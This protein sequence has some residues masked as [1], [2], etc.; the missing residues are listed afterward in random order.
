MIRNS[1][2]RFVAAVRHGVAPSPPPA[3]S[4]AVAIAGLIA[5]IAVAV[6]VVS[7]VT[8]R[9]DDSLELAVHADA[10]PT[11]TA[12]MSDATILGY[13]PT[14]TAV[15][16]FADLLLWRWRRRAQAVVLTV[17]MLGE[18]AWDE[19][20]KQAFHRARPDLFA[21]QSVHSFSFPSGHAFA[22]A[23]LLAALVALAWRRLPTLAGW[24]LAV[25]AA[26]LA[27]LIG[28]SRV[29]LGVH[30][31]SDILAGW[32]AA[33]AWLGAVGAW[34]RRRLPW[35]GS[36]PTDDEQSAIVTRSGGAGRRAPPAHDAALPRS[37]A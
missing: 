33:A 28:T 14:L 37:E 23:C 8:L 36:S 19:A 17:T 13:I 20:L 34:L 12:I 9:A 5:F 30:Y 10:T 22:T 4:L 26:C 3:W 25:L 11:L 1:Y 15:V 7:G 31:P 6:A 32:F 35:P 16:V 24:S 2:Q 21:R 18:G 29:Y 27:I